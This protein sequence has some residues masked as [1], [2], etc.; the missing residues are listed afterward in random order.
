[1]I[2]WSTGFA[3][4]RHGVGNID[5]S[6]R[7][8]DILILVLG[9]MS[10]FVI[11]SAFRTR[12]NRSWQE[13]TRG[14]AS[15]FEYKY[16]LVNPVAIGSR[17]A[18]VAISSDIAIPCREA[19]RGD[20]EPPPIQLVI[21]PTPATRKAIRCSSGMSLAVLPTEDRAWTSVRRAMDAAGANSVIVDADGRVVYSSSES[22]L[23]TPMLR[24]LRMSLPSHEGGFAFR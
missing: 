24:V 17:W 15:P 10:S 4:C 16:K 18:V 9:A 21:L 22:R 1:M 7:R 23:P 14:S 12:I 6:L 2:P 3:R 5:Q 20:P 13:Q 19:N 8:V 11:A